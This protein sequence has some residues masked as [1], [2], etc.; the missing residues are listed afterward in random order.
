MKTTEYTPMNR[1]WE[2][3]PRIDLQIIPRMEALGCVTEFSYRDRMHKRT[4]PNSMPMDS[5]SFTFKRKA[6]VVRIWQTK[7]GWQT[8]K[9]VDGYYTDHKPFQTTKLMMMEIADII[10]KELEEQN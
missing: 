2:K 4:N 8:A 7:D 9:L 10:C 1:E 6:D 3:S 5:V